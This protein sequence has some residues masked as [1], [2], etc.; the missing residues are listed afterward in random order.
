[1]SVGVPYVATPV[2]VLEQIGEVGQTHFN[3]AT[4]EEWREALKALIVDKERR[5][6]M[7]EAGRRHALAHF[8]LDAQA[9]KLADALRQAA[10]GS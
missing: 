6:K 2:G 9:D 8:T 3:A 4:K 5:R 1:M 7:G 10:K